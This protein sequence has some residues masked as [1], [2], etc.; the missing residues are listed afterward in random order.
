MK[1]SISRVFAV[2]LAMVMLVSV[3]CI[4][5]I[6][7]APKEKTVKVNYVV[8]GN[9]KSVEFKYSDAYFDQSG[10]VYRQDLAIASN[11]LAISAGGSQRAR[12][13]NDM[14]NQNQNFKHFASVCGFDKFASS[15]YMKARPKVDSIGVNCASKKIEDGKGKST[16]IA[17]AIRGF[18]YQNEWGDNGLIGVT[19]DHQGFS[20]SRDDAL[21]FVKQYIRDSGIKGRIKVWVSGYSRGGIVANM[22]GGSLDDGYNLGDKVTLSRDDMYVYPGEPALGVA[23]ESTK[24]AKYDNIHNIV[25]PNDLVPMVPFT[26]WGFA[27]YGIDHL[28]PTK[29]DPNYDEYSSAMKDYMKS[30]PNDIYNIYWPDLFQGWDVQT[31]GTIITG[32]SKNDKL[33]PEFFKDLD[34]AVSADLV[35]SRQDYVDNLQVYIMD[36]LEAFNREDVEVKDAGKDVLKVLAD[37]WQD[38]LQVLLSGDKDKA[39]NAIAGYI[40]EGYAKSGIT[41]YTQE[42][43]VKMLNVLVP[44]VIKMAKDYPSTTGTFIANIVN[45]LA[46]HS[47]APCQSWLKTLPADY[48]KT[49]TAYSYNY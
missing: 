20:R 44:R 27:R 36:L 16:L 18:G 23:T 9:D 10:Y 34:K 1:K 22:I 42:K 6:A 4:P 13:S 5:A 26:S 46:A 15:Q 49:H 35:Y 21:K 39:V 11:A 38:V 14:K 33:Q 3:V 37:N 24:N 8:S 7:S 17:I 19:G 48:M 47:E 31:N 28:T 25:N 41:N 12:K 43:I 2:L 32:I 40:E 29:A 45:I 30:I